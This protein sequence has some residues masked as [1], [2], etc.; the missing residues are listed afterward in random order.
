VLRG[1][2]EKLAGHEARTLL[3]T[4]SSLVVAALDGWDAQGL[5]A[6][7]TAATTAK[8]DAGDRSC[9]RPPLHHKW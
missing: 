2:Q 9:S 4:G 6:I 3:A 1:F 5:K 7:A 8:P